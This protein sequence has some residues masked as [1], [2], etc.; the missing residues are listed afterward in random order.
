MDFI[1]EQFQKNKQVFYELFKDESEELFIWKQTPEKW[2]LLEILCHLYDEERK[3]FRFRTKWV[4][5]KPNQ[6]PPPFNPIDWV[7]DHD[8]M[9]QDYNIILDKFLKERESS[10]NWLRSLENINWNHSFEH[11]KLG[12]MTAEYFLNNWLAHDYL[13]IRQIIKLKFDYLNNRFNEDLN[14]AGKW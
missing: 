11:P 2:C 13:H 8:Y 1:L 9:G 10:I 3:D 5:E 7:T 4:L 6:I 12:K 14:Y